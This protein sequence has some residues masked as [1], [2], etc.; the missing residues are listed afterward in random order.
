[1]SEFTDPVHV[2]SPLLVSVDCRKIWIGL[3]LPLFVKGLAEGVSGLSA[4][5]G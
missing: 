1:M 3:Q 2:F 5:I 4:L